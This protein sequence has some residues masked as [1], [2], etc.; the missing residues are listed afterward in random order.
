MRSRPAQRDDRDSRRGNPSTS[1]PLEIH[2]KRPNIALQLTGAALHL[3]PVKSL[4]RLHRRS[5]AAPAAERNVQLISSPAAR[6]VPP[7]ARAAKAAP[8]PRAFALTRHDL[9]VQIVIRTGSVALFRSCPT[10][11]R[12]RSWTLESVRS[13]PARA[14]PAHE[15]TLIRGPAP[16]APW[17][18]ARVWTSRHDEVPPREHVPNYISTVWWAGQP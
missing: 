18:R 8:C 4:A 10:L 13:Q 5:K 6:S 9:V 14:P 15:S 1:K 12:E 17:T 16:P 11:K 3:S 2:Q 7:G